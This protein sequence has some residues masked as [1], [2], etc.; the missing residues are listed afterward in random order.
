MGTYAETWLEFALTSQPEMLGL[1]ALIFLFFIFLATPSAC[2][3]S[4]ARDPTP[5]AAVT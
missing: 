4:Q 3:R 5:A 2:G 1:S